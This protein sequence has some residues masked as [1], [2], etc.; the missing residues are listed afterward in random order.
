MGPTYPLTDFDSELRREM[1]RIGPRPSLDSLRQAGQRENQW[2]TSTLDLLSGIGRIFTLMVAEFI[3][4]AAALVIAIVFALLEYWRVYHGA[5]ALGQMPEQAGLIAVAAVTANIIHPIYAVYARRDQGDL[6]VRRPTLRGWLAGLWRWITSKPE[7]RTENTYHNPVLGLAARVITWSTVLLAIYDV[8]GPLLT[9]IFTGNI[10][11]PTPI[12]ALE[13]LMGL[14]L[15]LAG[16]FFLQAA[17]HEIGVRAILDQPARLAEQLKVE[18]LEWQRKTEAAYQEV[19]AR[20]H[21]QAWSTLS[22]QVNALSEQLRLEQEARS[23]AESEAVQLNELVNALNER[24]NKREQRASRSLE[25]KIPPRAPVQ[26]SSAREQIASRLR[27]LDESEWPSV[28]ALAAE[29]GASRGTVNNAMND[30]RAQAVP[31]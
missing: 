6:I 30:A 3:R 22:A 14:G 13:L 9:Q 1:A 27:D 21:D 25:I 19:R 4:S 18:Q 20:V 16:V 12:M 31:Q 24:L 10:T 17:A 2:L 7:E 8:L 26:M 29:Y 11:R 23:K 5:S 15:S 28:S